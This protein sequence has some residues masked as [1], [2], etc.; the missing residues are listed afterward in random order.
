VR[1]THLA[2]G[3]WT[4]VRITDRGPFVAGRIIDLSPAAAGDLGML[5][6]GVAPVRLEILP[7]PLADAGG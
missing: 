7:A 6:D 1:V 3:R 5:E 4:I 2:S